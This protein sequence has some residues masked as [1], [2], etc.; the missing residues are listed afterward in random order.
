MNKSAIIT[1]DASSIGKD[2][3]LAYARDHPLPA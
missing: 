3:A 2:I 1:G